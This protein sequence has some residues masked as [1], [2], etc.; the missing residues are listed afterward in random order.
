MKVDPELYK[1]VESTIKSL[2]AEG[3]TAEANVLIWA[4]RDME[5]LITEGNSHRQK[6]DKIRD[7]ITSPQTHLRPLSEIATV[8]G[9]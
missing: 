3:K 8:L 7:I 1:A 4:E 9:L 6:L 5:K 2:M